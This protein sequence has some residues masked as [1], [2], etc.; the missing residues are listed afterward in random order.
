MVVI[1]YK[2]LDF[3]LVRSGRKQQLILH[4]YHKSRTDETDLDSEPAI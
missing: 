1:K 3:F 2:T 4:F